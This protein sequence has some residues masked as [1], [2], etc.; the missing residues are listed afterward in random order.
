MGGARPGGTGGGQGGGG[1]VLGN[2]ALAPAQVRGPGTSSSLPRASPTRRNGKKQE[3]RK[4]AHSATYSFW[5]V[6]GWTHMNRLE[7]EGRLRVRG[8]TPAGRAPG[9]RL[10]S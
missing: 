1:H 2:R 10:T 7:G 3:A 4:A 9:A 8:R 5:V 6:S